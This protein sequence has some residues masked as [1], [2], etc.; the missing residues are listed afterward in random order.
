MR[1][2]AVGVLALALLVT[3]AVLWM[4]GTQEGFSY[5]IEV[6]FIRVGSLL[7]VFWL[8]YSDLT[9]IPPWLWAALLP[10]LVIVVI[11]P[12][13]LVFVLPL[14]FLLAVLHPRVWSKGHKRRAP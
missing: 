9:R 8:A 6:N 5:Q 10:V 12:R 4:G 13:W 2:H 11:R 14:L 7:A 3:A 1:R